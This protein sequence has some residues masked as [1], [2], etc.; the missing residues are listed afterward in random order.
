VFFSLLA[1]AFFWWKVVT[2][3]AWLKQ[4]DNELEKQFHFSTNFLFYSI[5]DFSSFGSFASAADPLKRFAWFNNFMLV[6]LLLALLPLFFVFWQKQFQNA[7]R[8]FFGV[9]VVFAF[10]VFMT[11][12]ASYLLWDNLKFLQQ[13]QFPWRWLLI[14]SLFGSLLLALSIQIFTQKEFEI[15]GFLPPLAHYSIFLPLAYTI[16]FVVGTTLYIPPEKVE[17]ARQ[18]YLAE[19]G[20]RYWWPVW[21][22][23][24]SL[25]EKEKISVKNRQAEIHL[26]QPETREFTISAGES[27]EVRIATFYYPYWQATINSIPTTIKP[28]EDGLILISVPTET[29]NVKLH[30]VEPFAVK[31]AFAISG[32]T[33]IVLFALGFIT[34]GVKLRELK[35]SKKTKLFYECKDAE[36][37]TE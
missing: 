26:W 6:T 27:N 10:S 14:I 3:M 2:E 33:W 35:L 29:T 17:F 21:A 31:A 32:L 23:D 22:A 19:A 13:T 37:R 20:L 1:T 18:N 28:D 36:T 25:S 5:N 16:V 9:M 24:T 4:N 11:T 34:A 15:G 8:K 7:R 30:F 12:P